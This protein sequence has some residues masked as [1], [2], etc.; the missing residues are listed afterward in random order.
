MLSRNLPRRDAPFPESL[1]I[2]R[3]PSGMSAFSQLDREVDIFS[4]IVH[5]NGQGTSALAERLREFIPPIEYD[6]EPEDV[7]SPDE[8]SVAVD[9]V[10]GDKRKLYFVSLFSQVGFSLTTFI[11]IGMVWWTIACGNVPASIPSYLTL[12]Q[13]GMMSPNYGGAPSNQMP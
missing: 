2:I 9:G 4:K 6:S 3:T 1:A 12:Q 10:I 7:R 5:G 11:N 8:P 13:L